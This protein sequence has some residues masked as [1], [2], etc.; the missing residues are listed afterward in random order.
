MG[1]QA[2]GTVTK[3]SKK[4]KLFKSLLCE[5]LYLLHLDL[6]SCSQFLEA[7]PHYFW[8]SNLA[9]CDFYVVK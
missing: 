8:G 5:F 6:A 4:K 2:I 7:I 1:N 3:L 9:N